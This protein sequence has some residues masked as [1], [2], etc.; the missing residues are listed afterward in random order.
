MEVIT[1]DIDRVHFRIGDLDGLGIVVF[2]E[3]TLYVEPLGRRGGS[4]QLD[5]DLMADEGLAAPVLRDECKKPMLYTVPFAGP[6]R[7]VGDRNG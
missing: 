4:D 6:R 1:V 3:A 2:V 5:D 7:V